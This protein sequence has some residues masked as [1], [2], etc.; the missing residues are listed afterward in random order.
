MSI[1]LN[2]FSYNLIQ[3]GYLS[4][5]FQLLV[6]KFKCMMEPHATLQYST[7][8]EYEKE[9]SQCK[10]L[11]HILIYHF[12]QGIYDPKRRLVTENR[13]DQLEALVIQKIKDMGDE[14]RNYLYNSILK[15]IEAAKLP[16]LYLLVISTQI[17]KN[18]KFF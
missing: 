9:V 18:E 13:N 3:E 16:E 12:E 2:D 14:S 8:E 4:E 1:A 7:I 11:I 10:Y 17:S 5:T 15:K 6:D